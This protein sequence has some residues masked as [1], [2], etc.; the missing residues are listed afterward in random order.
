MVTGYEY[1]PLQEKTNKLT[2]APSEDSDQSGHPLS[3][4][5]FLTVR[6]KN[7]GSSATHLAH[8]EDS[9]QTGR[10]PRLIFA[11]CTDCFVGSVTLWLILH[12]GLFVAWPIERKE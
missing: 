11:G 8:S 4:I 1:K 2:F 9:D 5:R 6:M 12:Y 3:L 10:I 7:L